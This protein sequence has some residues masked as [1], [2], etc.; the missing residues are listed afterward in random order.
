MTGLFLVSVLVKR[1]DIADIAWGTGIFIVSVV[2]YLYGPMNMLATILLVLSGLW[3]LRLTTRIYLKNR[4]RPEDSR[5][6]KWRD[7]WRWFYLRSYFQVYL[8]QGALMV[9]MGYVFIH[10][11]A[12]GAG[13]ALGLMTGLG[14]LVWLIG[15]GFE[16]I[17]DYQLDRFINNP[18]NKGKIMSRGL[19][20]Y[21]R[22]PN[23]FG[24][25]T[26]WWGIWLMVA[27]ASL[28]V[29]ALLSPVTITILI[30]KVSGIPMLEKKFAENPAFQQ[31][32]RET[33]VFFPLPPKLDTTS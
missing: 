15:Y 5:Y 3:G 31:Y 18:E 11:A 2:A 24:E 13:Q 9:L 32:Q 16:V 30:F 4:K 25:V 7:T 1:N 22:H 10:F 14:V 21:S 29:F 17:A 23:Y 19:W 20:R 8:L 6:K 28:S 27:P 26:M 12:F 33:S